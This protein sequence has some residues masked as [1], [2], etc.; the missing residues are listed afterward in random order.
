MNPQTI[1]LGRAVLGE[2]LHS[3]MRVY[4]CGIVIYS[5]MRRGG[6]AMLRIWVSEK[7]RRMKKKN[8]AVSFFFFFSLTLSVF[9]VFDCCR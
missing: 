5:S 2:P 3:F 6:L 1:S 9:N 4:L 7:R 8:D